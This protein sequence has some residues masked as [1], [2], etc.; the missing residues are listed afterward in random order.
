[1]S[2]QWELVAQ[3]LPGAT[4]PARA[5][6]D[7]VFDAYVRDG[8]TNVVDVLARR[9]PRRSC[10]CAAPAEHEVMPPGIERRAA[11]VTGPGAGGG[12]N[13][14]VDDLAAEGLVTRARPRHLGRPPRRRR[15]AAP[16]GSHYEFDDDTGVAAEMTRLVDAA[17][18]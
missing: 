16:D 8:V 4:T 18:T 15:R 3:A 10:G 9:A 7:P 14:I 2:C 17:L 11:G 1:M 6:G 5:P 13:G 12:T